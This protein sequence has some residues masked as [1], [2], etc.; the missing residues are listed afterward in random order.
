MPAIT[1]FPD[2]VR[3]YNRVEIN[4]ADQAA[5]DYA[6]VLRVDEVTGQCTPLRPY[7]CYDGDY[8]N[9]SCDGH[10]IFWDT[11]VPLDRSVY[12][13]TEALS[14]A[15]CIPTSPLAVD[16]FG[17]TVAPG[18]WGNA[19]LGGAWTVSGGA[20]T[21]YSVNGNHGLMSLNTI[22]VSRRATLSAV[23]M[24]NGDIYAD[25]MLTVQ[26]TGAPIDMGVI[27]RFGAGPN[28]Y[29]AE[30]SY[31]TSGTM[32]VRLRKS[33]AGVFTTLAQG[34]VST[35]LLFAQLM[36][37]R[38]NMTGSTL[39]AKAWMPSNPEPLTWNAVATD[40]QL[41]SAGSVGLRSYLNVGN[42]NPSPVVLGFDNLLVT[43]SCKPCTPIT[44]QSAST[45]MPSGGAFRLKDPVRPYNDLYVPLCFAETGDPD[46]VPGSGVFFASMDTENYDS[47][48][49]L[50]NPTN[51]SSPLA[52]SRARRTKASVLQLVTRTFADRDDLLKINQAGSPLLFQGPPDYG[53]PDSYLSIGNI[54]VARGLTDHRYPVRINNLPLNTVNRPS[55]PTQGVRGSRIADLC[56]F[57]FAELASD[58]NTWEDLVRG[59]PTGMLPN[60]RTWDDVLADFPNWNG[61]NNGT[62]TWTGTEVGD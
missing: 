24:L 49:L 30:I 27:G 6:R 1:V 2:V 44:A 7:I 45:T 19:D 11:E 50:F 41:S 59:R 26:S 33:I 20:A 8:I 35:P 37:I 46:C 25:F 47:N 36:R 52:M 29:L 55:G 54:S 39:R 60:Y 5:V 10:G 22:N 12:Y 15:S 61:V 40:T 16:G 51:A 31:E 38:F 56:D 58:G 34:T 48:T 43:D 18:G 9:V 23:S 42:L 21:D 53:I 57:T 14:G 3:A 62:R 28:F 32:T 17:R 4:W 13:V